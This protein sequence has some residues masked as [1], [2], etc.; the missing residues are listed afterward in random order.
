MFTVLLFDSLK[1]YLHY[2]TQL[3]CIEQLDERTLHDIGFSRDELYAEA[4]QRAS[5]V[6]S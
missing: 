2:R 6:L 1:R 4:W 3:L 5:G